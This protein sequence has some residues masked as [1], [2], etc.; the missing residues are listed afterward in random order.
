MFHKSKENKQYND[1][2]KKGK[3]KKDGPQ[4]I[5]HDIE[6]ADEQIIIKEFVS[7]FFVLKVRV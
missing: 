1:Q 5:K 4:L 2:K 3:K 6:I 7:G